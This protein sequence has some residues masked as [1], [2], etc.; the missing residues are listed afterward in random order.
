MRLH[1][2]RDGLGGS[3]NL[4]LIEKGETQLRITAGLLGVV[5]KQMLD[6]HI[7]HRAFA[8]DALPAEQ[9]HVECNTGKQSIILRESVEWVGFTTNGNRKNI[10]A[11]FQLLLN[12]IVHIEVVAAP[13]L[14][15]N[16]RLCRYEHMLRLVVQHRL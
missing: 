12:D 10:L 16:H 6:E 5:R 14:V 2:R 7:R 11:G 13:L 1:T 4:Q 9:E 3:V 8:P 15:A